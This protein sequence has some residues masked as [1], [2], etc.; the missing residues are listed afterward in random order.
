MAQVGGDELDVVRREQV[1]IGARRPH[2]GGNGVAARRQ[3]AHEVAAEEPAGAGDQRLHSWF[4][5]SKSA[6]TRWLAASIS[7]T[8]TGG[9]PV[10]FTAA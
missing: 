5:G 10:P 8:G 3:L 9:G 6:A 1:R 2:H 4:P 7:A